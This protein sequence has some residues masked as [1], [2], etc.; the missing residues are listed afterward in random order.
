MT[1]GAT[2]KSLHGTSLKRTPLGPKILSVTKGCSS[3]RGYVSHT[4]SN[5]RVWSLGSS[6]KLQH[7]DFVVGVANWPSYAG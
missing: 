3:L 4:L 6:A 7:M 1:T 2:E 5:Y